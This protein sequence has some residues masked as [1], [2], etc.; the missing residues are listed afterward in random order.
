METRDTSP[1]PSPQ[2]LVPNLVLDPFA[3]SGTVGE[4]AF[5]MGRRFICI[6]LA[7]QDLAK[8]RIGVLA[9]QM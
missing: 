8:E 4:V 5:K 9:L 1:A 2:H 6:D 7:Y 3:G